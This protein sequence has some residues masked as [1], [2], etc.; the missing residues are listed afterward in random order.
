MWNPAAKKKFWMPVVSLG[1]LGAG[2]VCL[3]AWQQ[4]ALGAFLTLFGLGLGLFWAL[5]QYPPPVRKRTRVR[6]EPLPATA[7]PPARLAPGLWLERVFR[8]GVWASALA[9]LFW[10][11]QNILEG[12]NYLSGSF[13]ILSALVL[14]A[15]VGVDRGKLRLRLESRGWLRPGRVL[16]VLLVLV[17]LAWGQIFF[18]IVRNFLPGLLSTLLALG[19]GYW[20]L[21]SPAPGPRWPGVGFLGLALLGF[22]ASIGN[23]QSYVALES[24]GYYGGKLFRFVWLGLALAALFLLWN[25]GALGRRGAEYIIRE[26]HRHG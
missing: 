6:V 8:L 9:L 16:G 5:A 23:V 4:T 18:F 25:A 26:G 24:A 14:A 3:L 20:L 13:W 22:V 15:R 11:L 17:L 10:G 19:A 21:D 1:L 2:Q 7:S 12:Q